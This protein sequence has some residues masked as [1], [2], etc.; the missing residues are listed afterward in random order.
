MV[1]SVD[2]YLQDVLQLRDPGQGGVA[3][4]AVRP[5]PDHQDEQFPLPVL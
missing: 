3:A 4:P 2:H 5:K 1:G